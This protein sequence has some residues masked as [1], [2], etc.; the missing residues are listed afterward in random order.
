[1]K[2]SFRNLFVWHASVDLAV[3]ISQF[4]DVL[5]RQRRFSLADQ[6]QRASLSIPSNIAEGAGRQTSREIR[7]FYR[8]ARGSLFELETQL[9]VCR[10]LN[11]LRETTFAELRESIAK[12]GAGLSKLIAQS[13]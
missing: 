7:H 10:R 8:I 3:R 6:L 5:V 2:K 4:A 11:L 9:E 12:I 13:S 1:V